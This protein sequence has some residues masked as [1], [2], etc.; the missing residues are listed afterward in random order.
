MML[1]VSRLVSRLFDFG[2]LLVLARLLTPQDF[3]LVAIAMSLMQVVEAVFELPV[4]QVVVRAHNPE[5]AMLDTA[6]SLSLL[7]GLVLAVVLG[8]LLMAR[9]LF[10]G[11][12][13]WC[14]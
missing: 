10:S 4:A 5:P 3:G 12:R 7:R 6:F 8:D 1:V 9:A 14:R 13:R 11:N 2:A